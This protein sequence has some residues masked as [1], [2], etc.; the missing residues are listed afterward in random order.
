MLF[1]AMENAIGLVAVVIALAVLGILI[2]GR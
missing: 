1:K 2:G